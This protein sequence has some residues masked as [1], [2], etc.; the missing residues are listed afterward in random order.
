MNRR[1][2]LRPNSKQQ[3]GININS[4]TKG[5]RNKS[6]DNRKNNREASPEKNRERNEKAQSHNKN[7]RE[8]NSDQNKNQLNNNQRSNQ[9]K[10]KS[11][12]NNT[13]SQKKKNLSDLK[14]NRRTNKSIKVNDYEIEETPAN[15]KKEVVADKKNFTEIQKFVK[16]ENALQTKEQ[17][18]RVKFGNTFSSTLKSEPCQDI[19]DVYM[20][21]S[22]LFIE[23]KTLSIDQVFLLI[24]Y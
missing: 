19:K 9:Q 1:D 21:W 12:T 16:K 8:F 4:L 6:S 20:D 11:R 22:T 5:T 3:P 14:E 7:T 15:I 17:E 2:Q 10:N 13:N 18:Q 24:I 23:L